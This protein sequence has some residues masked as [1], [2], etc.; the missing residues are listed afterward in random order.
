MLHQFVD[1]AESMMLFLKCVTKCEVFVR[2][3]GAAHATCIGRISIEDTT[4]KLLAERDV[5]RNFLAANP[6]RKLFDHTST[7]NIFVQPCAISYNCT[8]QMK[9]DAE[10]Y[11]R[12][13]LP[14]LC[15]PHLVV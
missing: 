8:P 5:L 10:R 4:D 14:L 3:L 2:E 9:S 6:E 1:S 15:L 13:S 11:R 7:A 12:A